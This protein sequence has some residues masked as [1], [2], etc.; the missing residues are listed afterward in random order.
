MYFFSYLCI[1][2]LKYVNEY[3]KKGRRKRKGRYYRP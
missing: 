3:G 1:I 2:K